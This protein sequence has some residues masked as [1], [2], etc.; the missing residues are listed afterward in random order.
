MVADYPG[1][2]A[3]FSLNLQRKIEPSLVTCGKFDGSHAC[4][5]FA[6]SA[7]NILVHSPHRQPPANTTESHENME[8]RLEWNGEI[9]ELQI[10][11]QVVLYFLLI[12]CIEEL[13]Q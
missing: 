3:A 9:A 7:G 12:N 2:M 10:G 13:L 5:V 11:R 4:L 6:T 8:R 1:G